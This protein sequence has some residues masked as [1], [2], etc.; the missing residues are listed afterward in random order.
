MSSVSNSKSDPRKKSLPVISGP[1]VSA[2]SSIYLRLS[3]VNTTENSILRVFASQNNTLWL[4]CFSETSRWGSQGCLQTVN[5]ECKA[6][7]EMFSCTLSHTVN[8]KRRHYQ[9]S[10]VPCF[11][12]VFHSM[13]MIQ[14]SRA[15]STE[16]ASMLTWWFDNCESKQGEGKKHRKKTMIE[17]N[18]IHLPR[19]FVWCAHQV[20][21][22]TAHRHVSTAVVW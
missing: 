4:H 22:R 9:Y 15:Q 11:H 7:D 13:E 21:Y 16:M 10:A 20:F 8:H 3:R 17:E 2:M 5:E 12:L 6:L 14:I 1:K 19:S 18:V